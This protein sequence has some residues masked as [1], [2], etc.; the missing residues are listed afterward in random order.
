MFDTE[1]GSKSAIEFLIKKYS[2]K[3]IIFSYSSNSLPNSNFFK[4]IGKKNQMKT[5]IKKINYTYSFGTQ[6]KNDSMKNK[7]EEFI[8]TMKQN[9]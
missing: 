9:G 7:V 5:F 2:K 3:I 4:E 8:I 6:K 1:S